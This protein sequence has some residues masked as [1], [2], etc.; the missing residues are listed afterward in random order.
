MSI[1]DAL[2]LLKH[3][4]PILTKI[5]EITGFIRSNTGMTG[6]EMKHMI[7][8]FDCN[9]KNVFSEPKEEIRHCARN[10][11]LRPPCYFSGVSYLA[12]QER[13]KNSSL[14]IK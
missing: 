10:L 2:T 14:P 1:F 8:Q 5:R 12:E 7:I 9:N 13:Q 11:Y 4:L 6:I 3:V